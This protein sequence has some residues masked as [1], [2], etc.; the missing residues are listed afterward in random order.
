MIHIRVFQR[1]SVA[2]PQSKFIQLYLSLNLVVFILPRNELVTN[3][4]SNESYKEVEPSEGCVVVAVGDSGACFFFSLFSSRCSDSN[5]RGGKR[6][7]FL[8]SFSFFYFLS[9][10]NYYCK[11]IPDWAGWVPAFLLYP[12]ISPCTHSSRGEIT[13][14]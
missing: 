2:R 8:N 1:H 3:Q 7:F 12:Q 11:T 5:R 14:S 10:I 6:H 4:R 9:L 13:N